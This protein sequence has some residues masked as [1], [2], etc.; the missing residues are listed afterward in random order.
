MAPVSRW[1]EETGGTRGQ[2]YAARFA[3]LAASGVDVHGEAA[4]VDALLP[5]GAA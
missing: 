5:P 2:G 4:Y 1:L 3:E